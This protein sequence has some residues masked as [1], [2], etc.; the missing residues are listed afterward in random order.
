MFYLKYVISFF[1]VSLL[2]LT[3]SPAVADELE[4]ENED[5]FSD[6]LSSGPV[7]ITVTSTFKPFVSRVVPIILPE[8]HWPTDTLDISSDY[9]YRKAPCRSCSSDHKGIDFVPGKGEPVYA[10]MDGIVSKVGYSSGFGKHIYINHFANFN[11]TE[12]YKWQTIYAHLEEDTVP[13]GIIVGSL[14]SGGDKIATVGNTGTSTGPHLHFEILV[15][16]ENVDPEKYLK[17]YANNATIL[18]KIFK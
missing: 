2:F 3:G 1:I 15:D 7:S 4:I 16:G 12:F 18:D 13:N 10:A 11:N 14:V 8:M 5:I 17:M 9:G 6:I